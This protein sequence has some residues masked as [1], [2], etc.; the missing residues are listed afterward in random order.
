[1]G[2][3]GLSKEPKKPKDAPSGGGKDQWLEAIKELTNV[4]NSQSKMIKEQGIKLQEL[5]V[6]LLQRNRLEQG[7]KG[8]IETK[9]ATIEGLVQ[10]TQVKFG[11]LSQQAIPSPTKD[12]VSDQWPQL[13]PLH[14]LGQPTYFP[15]SPT[16]LSENVRPARNSPETNDRIITIDVSR[17]TLE[18]H[19]IS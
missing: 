19:S 18:K 12:L 5:E 14:R 1:M 15:T 9:L 8:I 16:L 2:G 10:E 3:K 13:P 6:K 11:C 4:I 17:S 7:E